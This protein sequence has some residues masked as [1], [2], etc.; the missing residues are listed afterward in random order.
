MASL[1]NNILGFSSAAILIL[2]SLNLP[3][4]IDCTSFGIFHLLAITF[5]AFCYTVYTLQIQTSQA[6][7]KHTSKYVRGLLNFVV[8]NSIPLLTK[9]YNII[10]AFS[11]LILC[12]IVILFLSNRWLSH[13]IIMIAIYIKNANKPLQQCST[14]ILTKG[15]KKNVSLTMRKLLCGFWIF[16]FLHSIFLF[17]FSRWLRLRANVLICTSASTQANTKTR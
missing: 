10:F 6:L 1:Q 14:D 5:H 9:N 7:N 3:S 11:S 12:H 13:H 2:P 16:F 4:A 15:V 8:I 17:I